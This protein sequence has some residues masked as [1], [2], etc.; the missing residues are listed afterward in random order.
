MRVGNMGIAKQCVRIS[1]VP[2]QSRR[3]DMSGEAVALGWYRLRDTTP[4]V[5]HGIVRPVSFSLSGTGRTELLALFG[6]VCA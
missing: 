5:I 2:P 1:R 3:R 4:G 6:T